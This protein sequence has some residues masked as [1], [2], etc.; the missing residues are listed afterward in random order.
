VRPPPLKRQLL[1]SVASSSQTAL[2]SVSVQPQIIPPSLVGF[3]LAANTSQPNVTIVPTTVDQKPAQNPAQSSPLPVSEQ[4]LPIT[5]PQDSVVPQNH[6]R[7]R[8][9]GV[10]TVTGSEEEAVVYN[11]PRL[12]E[13]P[14]GRLRESTYFVISCSRFYF[15]Y[16]YMA[17]ASD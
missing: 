5:Y 2:L 4:P 9:P 1:D 12:L 13:D 14:T 17:S 8:S 6:S 3:D 10:G 7:T 11:F 15:R 16:Q